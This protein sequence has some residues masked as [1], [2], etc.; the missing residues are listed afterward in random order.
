M[1]ARLNLATKPL[2]THRFFLLSSGAIGLVAALFFLFLQWH[3]YSVRRSDAAT[4]AK[5]EQ[6]RQEL[7]G[8]ER[9]R[10]E[11]LEFFSRPENSKLHDRSVFLNT[12]IDERS[13]NWTQMFMDLEK[14]LPGGVRVVSIAPEHGKS[15]VEVKLTVGAVS[16]DAKLKFL[17][18]L[19]QSAAF[20]HVQLVAEKLAT[21]AAGPDRTIVELT[22][23][24]SKS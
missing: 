5:V 14:I 20:T 6:V 24:Y 2:K 18:A 16:D 19:E 3:V 13:L 8:L 22:A 17:H 10:A 23:V 11:L 21:G 9:Q 7:S 12:L 15:G 1:K 4:R